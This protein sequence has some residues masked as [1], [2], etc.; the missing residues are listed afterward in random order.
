MQLLGLIIILYVNNKP[1]HI[2]PLRRHLFQGSFPFGNRTLL[3][4]PEGAF[5]LKF[6]KGKKSHGGEKVKCKQTN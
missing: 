1:M 4:R 3:T 5:P 2:R 6:R